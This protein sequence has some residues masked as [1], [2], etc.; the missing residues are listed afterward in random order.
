[1]LWNRTSCKTPLTSF[2]VDTVPASYFI[3]PH[4]IWTTLTCVTHAIALLRISGKCMK[5]G[6]STPFHSSVFSVFWRIAS[7]WV[8]R[9]GKPAGAAFDVRSMT[10]QDASW[11]PSWLHP[12]SH[13][14]ACLPSSHCT[15]QWEHSWVTESLPRCTWV[16][17]REDGHLNALHNPVKFAPPPPCFV[18]WSGKRLPE[19]LPQWVKL[20]RSC[21][22]HWH[23]PSTANRI[24]R[25]ENGA[26]CLLWFRK[27]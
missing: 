5:L 23:N 25:S 14:T 17:K 20:D 24:K 12:S 6:F 4:H 2:L 1:M 11:F 3:L 21:G 7:R 15:M 27:K 22:L 26:H 18:V 10:S 9:W 16:V 19:F 13:T 8:I